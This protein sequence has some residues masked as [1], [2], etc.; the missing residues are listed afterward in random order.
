MLFPQ[1]LFA[2]YE[3]TSATELTLGAN[4]KLSEA[5]RLEWTVE[6]SRKTHGSKFS[7]LDKVI[8][9]NQ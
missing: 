6:N 3:V 8:P 7:L 9:R 2:D 5:Q 4:Q 1:N